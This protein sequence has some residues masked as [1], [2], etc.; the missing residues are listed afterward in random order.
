MNMVSNQVVQVIPQS[1]DVY[2]RI[3]AHLTV[4]G[5]SINESIVQAGYAWHY[6]RYSSSVP[7]AN[8]EKIARQSSLGLWMDENPVPPWSFRKSKKVLKYKDELKSAVDKIRDKLGW[9]AN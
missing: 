6:K 3:V 1:Y 5:K 8:M 9:N 4:G 2:G 7:L